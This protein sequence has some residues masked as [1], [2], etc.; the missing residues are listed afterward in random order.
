M[1]IAAVTAIPVRLQRDRGKAEHTA[2]SPTALAGGDANYRW[3]AVFPALY[4]VNFETALVRITLDDGTIGWGEAQAPLAPEVACS[5]VQLLLAPVLRNAEFDGSVECIEM[6][7][8]RMYATMRIRGQTGGFM[9]DA[10]SGVDLALWDLAGKICN[11]PVCALL[12]GS[13]QRTEVPAYLSGLSGASIE[14][15][16]E[17]ACARRDEGF[18]AFKLF[19]DCESEEFLTSFS[20]VRK[21]LGDQAGIAADALWRLSGD[22]A[23]DFGKTLDRHNAMWLEAPLPPE[24]PLAHAALAGAIR[25]PL[26]IGE[27]YRTRYELASFFRERAMRYVQP[28]LGRCG[29][30]EGLRIARIAAERGVAVAPHLSIAMGPQIAAAIHFAAALPNCEMLEF[31]PNVLEVANESLTQ[32]IV[33]QAGW[34]RVPELPGLGAEVQL[35]LAK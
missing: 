19:Y 4:A 22:N 9:L 2:G 11:K 10:I 21:A 29:L 6:L 15:R 7:W 12:S 35:P 32:P 25:T 20:A 28:D 16:V 13:R 5:I 1:K 23:E 30:T 34:Y 18:R 26:A 27:S 31:N 8:D 33:C 3:S 14:A 17:N 24:D